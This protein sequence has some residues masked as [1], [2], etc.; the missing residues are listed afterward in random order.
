GETYLATPSGAE[1]PLPRGNASDI[2]V[3][4]GVYPSAG[5]DRWVAIAVGDD[6]EWQAFVRCVGWPDD[7]GLAT[8]AARLKA[9]AAID[10]RVAEWT[11]ARTADEAAAALQAAG[12]PAM[13]VQNADDQRADPHLAARGAIVTVVHP[14]IGP[15]RHSA[16]P[17]R[18]R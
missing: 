15:E 13:P 5:E 8:L 3:P 4:H 12:V 7:P 6:A 9:R 18:M 1:A 2:A 17:L 11:R 14:E 16:N 10:A